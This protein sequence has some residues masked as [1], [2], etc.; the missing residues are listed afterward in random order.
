METSNFLPQLT[1]INCTQIQLKMRTIIS[2]QLL[3]IFLFS[4]QFSVKSQTKR[5][6]GF[7]ISGK[8]F[9]YDR[10][11]DVGFIKVFEE[12]EVVQTIPVK[13]NGKFIVH[14]PESKLYTL[15]FGMKGHIQKRIAITTDG[16]IFRNSKQNFDFDVYLYPSSAFTYAEKD[17]LDY[18]VA[19][20]SFDPKEK[21]LVADEKYA[22]SMYHNLQQLA[23]ESR[24]VELDEKWMAMEITK[25]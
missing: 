18:P 6:A 24:A 19:L 9:T 20:I 12:N 11:K 8:V 7:L 5:S 22:I 2:A 13:K 21:R 15:E 1:A 14:L 25:K 10:V 17:D 3:F 16:K 4:F 23:A